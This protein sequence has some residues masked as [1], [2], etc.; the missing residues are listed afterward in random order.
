M[1]FQ[2]INKKLL[3]LGPSLGFFYNKKT[4][5]YVIFIWKLFL[6]SNRL[7]LLSRLKDLFTNYF[8]GLAVA[9]RLIPF[10]VSRF[11]Y[12]SRSEKQN[13]KLFFF[14]GNVNF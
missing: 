10:G 8:L 1:V 7:V 9:K 2:T 3:E 5:T 14:S 11:L 4:C 12:S 13:G 6:C